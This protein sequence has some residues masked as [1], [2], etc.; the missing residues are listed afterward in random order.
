[1]P[2]V[3][4]RE[5]KDELASNGMSSKAPEQMGSAQQVATQKN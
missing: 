2:I 3:P 4:R 1:M 5:S